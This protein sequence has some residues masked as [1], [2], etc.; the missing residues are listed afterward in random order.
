VHLSNATISRLVRRL[1]YSRKK[2]PSAR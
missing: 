2:S 1:R